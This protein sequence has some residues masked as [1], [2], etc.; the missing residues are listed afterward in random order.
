MGVDRQRLNERLL[1]AVVAPVTL[2]ALGRRLVLRRDQ[3]RASCFQ[4]ARQGLLTMEGDMVAP[5][6]SHRAQHR[7]AH[8]SAD[9][10]QAS[11]ELLDEAH[12]LAA[13]RPAPLCERDQFH[14]SA[15]DLARR[16]HH[17]LEF[18]DVDG[19]DVLFVGDDD[20]CSAL[21]AAVAAPRRLVVV[22]NDERVLAALERA[23]VATAVPIQFVHYDLRRYVTEELPAELSGAFDTFFA[24]PPYTDSG[25]M[26]FLACGLAALRPTPDVRAIAAVPWLEREEWSHELLFKVQR[27]LLRQ[28]FVLTDVRR[29]FHCYPAA[30]HIF[31]SFVRAVAVSSQ[32]SPRDLLNG[33]DGSKLYAARRWSLP[34]GT[35]HDW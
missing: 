21:L 32:R 3:L 1:A 15:D 4:L 2:S 13:A 9:S 10:R 26:L 23:T 20:F 22:D 30:D 6:P 18:G 19:R 28:G 24:D 8:R 35:N 16:A 5:G 12:R 27:A 29:A 25:M 31:S 17:L 11:R 34:K 14:I 7:R 33:Y